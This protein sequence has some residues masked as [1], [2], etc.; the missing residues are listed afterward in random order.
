MINASETL[1]LRRYIQ[2]LKAGTG[3]GRLFQA[4]KAANGIAW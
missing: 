4:R 1:M 2:Q 3:S